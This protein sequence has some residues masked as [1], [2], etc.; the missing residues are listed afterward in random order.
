M[1]SI[2][3][4]LAPSADAAVRADWSLLAGLGL[5]SRQRHRGAS[6][7][8]HLSLVEAERIEVP[9]APIPPIDLVLTGL[10]VLGMAPRGLVLARRVEVTEGLLALRA[11]VLAVAEGLSEFSAPDRWTPHVTLGSRMSAEQ[12]DTAIGALDASPVTVAAT[13]ARHWN[14]ETRVVTPLP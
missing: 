4:L 8:P 9:V 11:R 10:V 13:S 5:P 3:L 1:Q 7:A 2:E 6:N 12:I 14:S